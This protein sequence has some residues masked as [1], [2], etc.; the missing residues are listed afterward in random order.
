VSFLLARGTGRP[1]RRS[2]RPRGPCPSQ[3]ADDDANAPRRILGHLAQ[4]LH[5]RRPITLAL[6]G[7]PH[8]LAQLIQAAVTRRTADIFADVTPSLCLLLRR[9]RFLAAT[10]HAPGSDLHRLVYR[11][12]NLWIVRFLGNGRIGTPVRW[13]AGS[14][15]GLGQGNL[16]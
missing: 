9:Q 16:R 15:A 1:E 8:A 11:G 7:T 2:R 4:L 3:Q 14:L 13:E 10:F 12:G 6:Q 5:R